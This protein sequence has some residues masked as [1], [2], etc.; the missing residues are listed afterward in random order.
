VTTPRGLGPCDLLTV[1][2]ACRVLRMSDR[3]GRAFLEAR[4]LV[5]HFAGRPRVVAGELV[6]AHDEAD[7]EHEPVRQV[8]PAL[9]R[10]SLAGK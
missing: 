10:V 1:E 5:R 7:Q 4:G 8:G 6:K 9:R 2:A 3:D